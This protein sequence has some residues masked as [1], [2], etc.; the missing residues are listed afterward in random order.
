M[1]RVNRFQSPASTEFVTVIAQHIGYRQDDGFGAWAIR[2]QRGPYVRM[3]NAAGEGRRENLRIGDLARDIAA[4]MRDVTG[5]KAVDACPAL[6]RVELGGVL[7]VPNPVL[8]HLLGNPALV[9]DMR[10]P[11]PLVER[12]E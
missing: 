12:G 5:G 7:K 2:I 10:V 11:V 4:P 1:I 9:A 8:V 6:G 3:L